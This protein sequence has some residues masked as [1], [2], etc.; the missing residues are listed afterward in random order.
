MV[1]AAVCSPRLAS[2]ICLLIQNAGLVMLM[3]YSR[4]RRDRTMFLAS[5]AVAMDE[6]SKFLLSSVM[7][8]VNHHRGSTEKELADSLEGSKSFTEY[9]R[10]QVITKYSFL[11]AV[12]ALLY[13]VQKNLL[14]CA[15]SNLDACVYQVSY[16]AKLLTT[17]VFSYLI[18]G[19]RFSFWQQAGLFLLMI[20]VALVQVSQITETR[21][22]TGEHP[23]LG[24]VAV[25][26]AC[27]TSGF[28]SVY[29]EYWLKKSQDFWVKQAQLAFFACVLAMGAVLTQ[30]YSAVRD[31]GFFQG[32]D[33]IVCLTIFFEAGGGII[34]ALVTK[35][36]DSIAKNFATALSLTL[37]TALCAIFWEFHVS[38]TFLLG[39]SST[40]AATYI[41]QNS[42]PPMSKSAGIKVA[43]AVGV[44]IAVWLTVGPGSAPAAPALDAGLLPA[45]G[46][47][48]GAAT[49][50]DGGGD[51]AGGR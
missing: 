19:K 8:F 2:L 17:A 39:A 22:P 18:L 36:A 34:V 28:A 23:M 44:L 47:A 10:Q 45:Q 46:G 35:Y 40:L 12:P 48:L 29:F 20:G 41:Y 30:D 4:S 50:A 49:A 21:K 11:M 32:Y 42:A 7:I 37:T 33:F 24:F 5:T 25:S 14:Y 51:A 27:V 16:S 15:L 1:L 3:R 31:A 26:L 6:L 13:T 9:L 38:L 43:V